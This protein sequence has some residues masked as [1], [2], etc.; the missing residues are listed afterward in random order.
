M[1]SNGIGFDIENDGMFPEGFP[2]PEVK[3]LN[4]SSEMNNYNK[5][6]AKFHN[7]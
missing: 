7:K 2:T 5:F 6:F 4:E 1:K 3:S